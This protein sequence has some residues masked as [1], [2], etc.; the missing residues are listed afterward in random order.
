[1]AR[2][3]V[4]IPAGTRAQSNVVGVAILIGIT[5]LSLGALTAAVGTVVESNAAA[6]DADRVAADLD[7]AVQPVETTGP[8]AGRV[9]FTDGELR[10]VDR[11]IR[12]HDGDAWTNVS[13]GGLVFEAGAYRV[14]AV[15]GAVVR[16]HGGSTSMYRP[17][18]VAVSDDVALVGVADLRFDG[19]T[20]VSGTAPTTV[21][22]RTNVSHDRQSL[23]ETGT[24]V[25][26]ETD[27][28]GAWERHFAEAGATVTRR[29]FDGDD[30]DS[31]VA[32]FGDERTAYLVVHEVAVEVERV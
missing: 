16:D 5:M 11:T 29:S 15:G 22:V 8:H 18:P 10:T 12:V 7:A 32:T 21:A 4:A 23:G 6:V 26:V 17:P 3:T 14:L 13:A 25:A 20:A 30:H 28:P 31:V 19:H 24:T 9:S 2:R 27:A 1:M